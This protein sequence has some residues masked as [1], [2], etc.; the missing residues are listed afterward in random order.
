MSVDE[1]KLTTGFKALISVSAKSASVP[2]LA[3]PHTT[4]RPS[5][6]AIPSPTP[7][8]FF[9]GSS[10]GRI[11][12]YHTPTC[13]GGCRLSISSPSLSN[14]RS[15]TAVNSV[16]ISAPWA[17]ASPAFTGPPRILQPPRTTS[18]TDQ[19][20][21]ARNRSHAGRGRV[22]ASWSELLRGPVLR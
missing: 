22:L 20:Y 14:T 5:A 18:L 11:V 12:K 4:N 15:I 10:M 7:L 9:I 8:L 16:A 13:R 17:L 21:G 6:T 19:P 2:A 3:D 1:P